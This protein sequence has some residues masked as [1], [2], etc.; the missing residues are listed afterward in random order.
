LRFSFAIASLTV[1]TIESQRT[2]TSRSQ[3][4]IIIIIIV[5]III[6]MAG[7]YRLVS[8]SVLE[9]LSGGAEQ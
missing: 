1:T 5:I 9:I 7:C 2:L 8:V 6:I 4:S 3:P